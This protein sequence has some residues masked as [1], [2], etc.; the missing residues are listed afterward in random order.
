[1]VKLI[2]P[3][4]LIALGLISD[5]YIFHRYIGS[6][7][8]WRWA[9]WL[10]MA[11]VIGFF[12]KFIFFSRGLAAD[13]PVTNIFLLVLVLFMVP[14]ML[15][16]LF[17]LI[18]KIGTHLGLFLALGVVYIVLYGITLGFC[19]FQVR[20][21]VYESDEI[22]ASFDGYRIAQISDAHTGSF[23]G[24]YRNLLK[25]SID[26]INALNPDLVCFVGDIENFVP[27][28]LADH[29]ATFSSLRAKDGV[30]TIMGNHD[31]SAYI[32]VTPRERTTMVQQTRD[33][34][35]TFGWDLIENSHRFIHRGN[36]SIL[37]VGEENWGLPPFPQYGDLKKATRGLTVM[38]DGSLDSTFCIMLSH[39]PTAWK[40]HI[41]PFFSPDITLSGHTHGTQFSLFGWSP[42]SMK[43]DEWGGEYTVTTKHKTGNTT[44]SRNCL[45][46][47]S[48][49]IGGNFPFRF[50][51]PRE[52][53]LITLKRKTR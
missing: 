37:I 42:A 53:V 52:V 31:Y 22:P 20:E 4:L 24:P 49:G 2:V 18:P 16:A 28:E 17:S 3:I 14:K 8:M 43:Y 48:T 39:D 36:D 47:V 27:E 10:P 23:Y 1:M 44:S 29:K 50:N 51:M 21:I 7:S 12:L 19:K 40:A 45:L 15:F 46:S 11:I 38:P 9:W 34:Q 32:N 6:S 35:R 13:Y 26:S 41:L 33:L 30:M 25:K 5:A